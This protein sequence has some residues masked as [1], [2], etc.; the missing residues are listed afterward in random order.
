MFL[1]PKTFPLDTRESKPFR[2]E[3]LLVAVWKTRSK[4]KYEKNIV[5][6][7][8]VGNGLQ[9]IIRSSIVQTPSNGLTLPRDLMSWPF[10]CFEA[11]H[12]RRNIGG[13]VETTEHGKV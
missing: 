1:F 10:S 6:F 8:N 5:C 11:S 4:K 13:L 2:N 7:V 12:R 9:V 3:G